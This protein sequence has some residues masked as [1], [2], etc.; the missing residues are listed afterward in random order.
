MESLARLSDRGS[1]ALGSIK[2]RRSLKGDFQMIGLVPRD[3]WE[4]KF[5]DLFRGFVAALG[6]RKQDGM[7]HLAELVTALLRDQAE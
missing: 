1:S 4:H 7:L 5:S 6:P 2:F 3:H